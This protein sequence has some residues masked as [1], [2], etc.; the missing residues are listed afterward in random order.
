M[1][2]P[3]FIINPPKMPKKQ[4]NLEEVKAFFQKS[5]EV[6]RDLF[7]LILTKDTLSQF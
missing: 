7:F 6:R 1:H 2:Y 4:Y 3:D 5:A